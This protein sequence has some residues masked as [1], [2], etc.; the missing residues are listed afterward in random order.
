MKF[1]VAFLLLN[2]YAL[3]EPLYTEPLEV[4]NVIIEKIP[5]GLSG[6]GTTTRYWDCCK[7]TCSWPGNVNYK[8]PVKS[9]QAD[10]ITAIDPE[11]QSGCVGGAAYV[12]T[13]QAQRSVNDSIA[14]VPIVFNESHMRDIPNFSIFDEGAARVTSKNHYVD[15]KIEII[16]RINKQLDQLYQENYHN[17]EYKNNES[18]LEYE[19]NES[20]WKCEEDDLNNIKGRTFKIDLVDFQMQIVQ[21]FLDAFA[22]LNS[23][24]FITNNS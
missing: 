22:H 14:L 19:T 12:C 6:S 15:R 20:L 21:H 16:E 7:P 24:V 23:Q 5:G 9:C 2:V 17:C 10:G 1:V 18:H 3:A 4:G 13:N 8:T 11:T